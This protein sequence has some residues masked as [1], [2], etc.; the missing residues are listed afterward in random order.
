MAAITMREWLQ[1]LAVVLLTASMC[2]GML[3]FLRR[4]NYILGAE[5]AVMFVSGTNVT[6]WFF[7]QNDWQWNLVWYLDAFSRIAGF[8]LLLYV[9][10]A[11]ITHGF[12]PSLGFDAALLLA[13]A[14]AAAGVMYVDVLIPARHYA[15]SAAHFAFVPLLLFLV[16]EM[17]R[18]GRTALALMMAITTVLFTVSTVLL[19]FAAPAHDETNVVLNKDFVSMMSWAFGYLVISRVYVA[20]ED[21]REAGAAPSPLLAPA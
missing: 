12:R 21:A 13:I 7:T 14:A 1:L 18:L 17:W 16:H 6:I 15:F 3:T 5:W 9:G 11:K 8:N 19:D 20:M 4:Q 2:V 10:F